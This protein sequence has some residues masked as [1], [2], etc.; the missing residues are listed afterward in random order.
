MP[1]QTAIRAYRISPGAQVL[2]A[3]VVIDVLMIP[4]GALCGAALSTVV[5][6]R[7]ARTVL[8]LIATGLFG[9]QLGMLVIWLCLMATSLYWCLVALAVL[10]VLLLGL[11]PPTTN[12]PSPSMLAIFAFM[13]TLPLAAFNV[14][15]FRLVPHDEAS[16]NGERRPM[17]YSLGSL[18]FWTFIVAVT[19]AAILWLP[20]PLSRRFALILALLATSAVAASTLWAVLRPGAV[21]RRIACAPGAALFVAI[22]GTQKIFG[23]GNPAVLRLLV[24]GVVYIV[25]LAGLLAIYRRAGLRLVHKTAGGWLVR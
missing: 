18:F 25:T 15:G 10:V 21:W 22:L 17:R 1:S 11:V 5:G 13:T 14:A 23:W 16:G 19:L 3:C 7:A 4:L 12:S 2:V 6:D 20:A 24:A 8:G 9:A